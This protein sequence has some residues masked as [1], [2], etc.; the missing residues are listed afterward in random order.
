[1][2][3]VQ[4]RPE[5]PLNYRLVDR[6][7]D[8]IGSD[9]LGSGQIPPRATTHKRQIQETAVKSSI[10]TVVVGLCLAV[11]VTGC[12][13]VESAYKSASDT[14]SDWFKSDDKKDQKR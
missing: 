9:I 4:F 13:T 5:P 2:S 14:V 7:C 10:K 12:A 1:M 11:L 8:L 6:R 3:V